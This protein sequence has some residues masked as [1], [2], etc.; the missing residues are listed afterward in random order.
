[1][2]VVNWRSELERKK[3]EKK[4]MIVVNWR[5]ELEH[6]KMKELFP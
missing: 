5:N 1:M 6:M 2:W 3:M 4:L